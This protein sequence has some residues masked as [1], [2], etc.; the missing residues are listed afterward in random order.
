MK[1]TTIKDLAKE[2]GVSISTVSKALNDSHEIS[3]KTKIK[4]RKFAAEKNYKPNFNALSLKKK[5]TKTIGVIIPNMLNYFYAQVLKGIEHT[6]NDK[7]YK[8]ITCIS[9]ESHAKEAEIIETLTNGSIDGFIISLAKETLLRNKFEHLKQTQELGYPIVMFDRTSS[10]ILSDKVITDDHD[11]CVRAIEHLYNTGCKKI[12][13]VSMNFKLEKEQNRFDAY[14]DGLLKCNL[15]FDAS[16]V[17]NEH[18]DYYKKYEKLIK[19]LFENKALD[20][21]IT[22]DESTAVAAIKLALN[23]G[24]KIPENFSVI[25]FMNG[26]LARHSNPRLSTISQHGEKMGIAT[27]EIIIN[28]LENPKKQVVKNHIIQTDL[29]ER[30]STKSFKKLNNIKP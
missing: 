3:E 4:I 9:N 15:P 19:P 22:T 6:A 5:T 17:I 11:G 26:I 20:A 24:H 12:G 21:L 1:K 25:C 29:V 16:L 14:K 10:R 30:N 23:K 18:E 27:A 13:F 28:R 7:G 8:I 2:L